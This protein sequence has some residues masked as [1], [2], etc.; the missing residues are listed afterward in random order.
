MKKRRKRHLS[1]IKSN[2]LSFDFNINTPIE[3]HTPKSDISSLR[4]EL[5]WD[6]RPAIEIV[7]S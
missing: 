6:R 1:E 2:Q 3:I 7:K 5:A 4:K